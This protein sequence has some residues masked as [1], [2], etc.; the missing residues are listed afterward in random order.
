VT[1]A[2][3]VFSAIPTTTVIVDPALEVY[4]YLFPSTISFPRA[5]FISIILAP[6]QFQTDQESYLSRAIKPVLGCEPGIEMTIPA[7]PAK[8][9]ALDRSNLLH[10]PSELLFVEAIADSH[11]S[12]PSL[13]YASHGA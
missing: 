13:L 6:I 10:M 11:L 2:S 1:F 7:H 5:S 12:L 8:W 9:F 4:P 3:V